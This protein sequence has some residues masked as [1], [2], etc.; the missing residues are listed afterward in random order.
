MTLVYLVD[1]QII[2]ILVRTFWMVTS[3]N[4]VFE[5]SIKLRVHIRL[6]VV[7]SLRGSELEQIFLI[8]LD[9]NI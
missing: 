5:H 3:F 8:D 9:L 2:S 1:K 7:R 4:V 6:E